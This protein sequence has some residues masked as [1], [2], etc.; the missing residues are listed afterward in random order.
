L[1]AGTNGVKFPAIRAHLKKNISDAYAGLDV[2]CETFPPDDVKRQ[3]DAYKAA[4]D[5]LSPGDVTTIFTPDDTHFEIAK[6]A[7]ERG[8]HVLVTKPPVKTLADHL[9]LMRLA[10]KHQVLVMVEYHKRWVVWCGV[11]SE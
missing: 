4:L 9:E 6:Y 10:E 11:A 8:I 3:T 5:T 7:I 2:S 1:Q